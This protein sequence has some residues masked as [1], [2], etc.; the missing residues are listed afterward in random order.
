MQE[1]LLVCVFVDHDPSDDV[2]DTDSQRI[3]CDS[4][5]IV[6]ALT[7]AYLTLPHCVRQLRWALDWS[8]RDQVQ[9]ILLTLHPA[10]T[11]QHLSEL[12]ADGPQRCVLAHK[13]HWHNNMCIERAVTRCS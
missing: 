8:D 9:L 6:V 3:M 5:V 10:C 1:R 7:P 11:I 12:L 4:Q 2:F 13:R